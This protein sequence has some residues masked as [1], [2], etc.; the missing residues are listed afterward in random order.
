MS[1]FGLVSLI[2]L[3]VTL[4]V[5]YLHYRVL[6]LRGKMD[7]CRAV[8][9]DLL[10]ENYMYDDDEPFPEMSKLRK[11]HKKFENPEIAS[12]VEAYNN[13]ATDYNAYI[14]KEHGRFMAAILGLSKEK[15]L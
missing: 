7:D 9:D 12:A 2:V 8:I 13:A 6:K 14:T 15:L 1:G 5:M 11:M 4:A 3:I 10:Q